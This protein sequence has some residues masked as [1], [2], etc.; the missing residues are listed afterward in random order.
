M[1]DIDDD[2]RRR[3]H[4]VLAYLVESEA[5]DYWHRRQPHD[6]ENHV[7]ANVPPLIRHLG[8]EDLQVRDAHVSEVEGLSEGK[9]DKSPW[10]K[11][12]HCARRRLA[13]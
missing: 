10:G 2:T 3:L 4:D 12:C 1:A 7:Y 13:Q 9:P 11:R 5:N 6:R 8:F